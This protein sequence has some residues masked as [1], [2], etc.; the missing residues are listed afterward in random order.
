MKKDFPC[1]FLEGEDTYPVSA[2]PS[3]LTAILKG[4]G[5]EDFAILGKFCGNCLLRPC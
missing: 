1:G 3:D 2:Q 5:D 4:V